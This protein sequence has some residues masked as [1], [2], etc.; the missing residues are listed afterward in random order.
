MKKDSILLDE[1]SYNLCL[2]MLKKPA[3]KLDQTENKQNNDRLFNIS[4]WDEMSKEIQF[5]EI[6]SN[7]YT[8]N[9]INT[10]NKNDYR[11]IRAMFEKPSITNNESCLIFKNEGDFYLKIKDYQLALKSYEYALSFL[12]ITKFNDDDKET[13][14]QKELKN[15]IFMNIAFSHIQTES[16]SKAI[17]YLVESNIYDKKNLKTIYRLAFVYYKL[18]NYEKSTEYCNNGLTSDPNNK[19]F[20]SLKNDIINQQTIIE[21][22]S[23]KLFKK[24]LN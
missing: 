7:P 16:Y 14:N 8:E 22:K 21:N 18:S 3:K 15:Q 9:A 23:K 12:F 1:A 13:E 19:E 6:V 20:I 2:E 4:K 24:L 5:E 11:K 10:E 17:D